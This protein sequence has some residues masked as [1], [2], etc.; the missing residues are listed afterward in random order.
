MYIF[1]W[2]Y[3]RLSADVEKKNIEICNLSQHIKILSKSNQLLKAQ[4]DYSAEADTRIV[5][6]NLRQV[7]SEFKQLASDNISQA[8]YVKTITN[9]IITKNDQI[10]RENELVNNKNQFLKGKNLL[11]N[12]NN[13]KDEAKTILNSSIE[14]KK[15]VEETANKAFSLKSAFR[16]KWVVN[17]R[18][19]IVIDN[20]LKENSILVKDLKQALQENEK[21][22]LKLKTEVKE[23]EKIIEE[24][25]IKIKPGTNLKTYILFHWWYFSKNLKRYLYFDVFNTIG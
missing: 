13:I 10:N 2:P 11:E 17:K 14:T 22:I 7:L 25:K 23:K 1:I 24:L 6:T 8:E 9:N 12:L 3:F 16:E 20:E 5:L 15:I 4:I 19:R 18:P 21:E